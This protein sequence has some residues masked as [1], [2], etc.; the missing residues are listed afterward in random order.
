MAT[1]TGHYKRRFQYYEN[2]K[3]RFINFAANMWIEGGPYGRGKRI[4]RG[5]KGKAT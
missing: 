1:A 2:G 4:H 5:N 3:E